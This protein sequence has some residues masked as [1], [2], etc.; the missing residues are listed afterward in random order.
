MPGSRHGR[1]G[2]GS[3]PC[4]GELSMSSSIAIIGD[5]FMLPAVFADR[6]AA[7]C[8]NRLDIRMLEQPWPDQPMEHG[9]AGSMLR[10]L[11]EDIGDPREVADLNGGATFLVIHL[12]PI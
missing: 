11:E 7:G 6:I 8:G 5:R 9:Y 4:A 12:A 10:G 1:S 2:K 3:R